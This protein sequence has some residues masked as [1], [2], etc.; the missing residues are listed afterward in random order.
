M[1]LKSPNRT[2]FLKINKHAGICWGAFSIIIF[3]YSELT[4]KERAAHLAK[5]KMD[6]FVQ[7]DNVQKFYVI[8]DC[9]CQVCFKAILQ[10][11]DS[12]SR[13]ALHLIAWGL[14][15]TFLP[16]YFCSC[17]TKWSSLRQFFFSILKIEHMKVQSFQK[18]IG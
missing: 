4:R 17:K 7:Y 9:S 2:Y 11:L 15:Q 13:V 18:A 3:L 14:W 16:G 12:V 8:V 6:T 1:F 10:F 5:D